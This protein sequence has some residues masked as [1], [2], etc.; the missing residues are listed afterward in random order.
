MLL[1]LII[2]AS[3]LVPIHEYLQ[4]KVIPKL[5]DAHETRKEAWI[6]KESKKSKK[7]GV[8]NKR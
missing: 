2:I 8:E 3:A 4:E 5:L 6:E 1:S 7:K